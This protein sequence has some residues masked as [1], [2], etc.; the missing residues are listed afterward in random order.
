M[1][2]SS[3]LA[4]KSLFFT[5]RAIGSKEQFDSGKNY[6]GLVNTGRCAVTLAQ[7]AV[8]LFAVSECLSRTSTPNSTLKNIS[9][10]LYNS[11]LKNIA[12]AVTSH[13]TQSALTTTQ[14]IVKN[15]SKLGIAANIAYA[16]AKCLDADEDKKMETVLTA[17]G[18]CAGMYLFENIYSHVV[19]PVKPEAMNNEVSK[20]SKLFKGKIKFL[21]NIKA[22]SIFLGLGFVIASFAGCWAGEA[23]GEKISNLTKMNNSIPST[24]QKDKSDESTFKKVLHY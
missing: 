10:S 5:T 9:T 23:L 20:I 21:N 4:Y 1:D 2:L 3:V 8:P 18:N 6:T 13:S 7:T 11:K 12:T 24:K 22:S 16:G 17:G 15:L 19:K 14:K